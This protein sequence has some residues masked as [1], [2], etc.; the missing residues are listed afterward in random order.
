MAVHRYQVG[1]KSRAG[2]TCGWRELPFPIPD[3]GIDMV[4]NPWLAEGALESWLREILI[5]AAA[6]LRARYVPAGRGSALS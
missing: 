3:L 6:P 2:S 1:L 4:W 5:E